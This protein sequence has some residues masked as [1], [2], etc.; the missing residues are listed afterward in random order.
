MTAAAPRGARLS[1][2]VTLSYG[3]GSIAYGVKDAGF[4]TFL[5]IY[6]NQVV[7][8]NPG[9]VGLVIMLALVL[10]AFVDPAVG[11]FSDRTQPRWGRRHPWMYAS[12]VPIAVGWLLLWNPP[13]GLAEPAKLVWLFVTAV[14]VR[15]AVSCYE[16][17]T[18]PNR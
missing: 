11:L 14:V 4:G 18:Q 3:L 8:V 12:A 7:G 6:Y 16:V 2:G 10:D 13:A 17:P 9:T 15:S 5:L 1:S